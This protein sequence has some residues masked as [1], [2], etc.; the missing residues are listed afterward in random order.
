MKLLISALFLLLSATTFAHEMNSNLTCR[1]VSATASSSSARDEE[2]NFDY[3]YTPTTTKL[4]QVTVN[5]NVTESD[6][7]QID[8]IINEEG[9]LLIK[10]PR[11]SVHGVVTQDGDIIKIAEDHGTSWLSHS[12]YGTFKYNLSKKSA[13]YSF[14]VT[15]GGLGSPRYHE[16]SKIKL[17][18]CQER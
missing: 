2:S 5:L 18:D 3:E 17:A 4:I 13:T 8:S 12:N 7:I 9:M 11:V 6:K 16:V 15:W 10:N 14:N 1:L